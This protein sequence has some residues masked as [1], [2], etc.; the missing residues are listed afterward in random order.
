MKLSIQEL[1]TQL[2]NLQDSRENLIKSHETMPSK[3]LEDKIVD[4][5][6]RIGTAQYE[7]NAKKFFSNK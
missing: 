5:G 2:K 7:I 6:K 3:A 4:L 1:K